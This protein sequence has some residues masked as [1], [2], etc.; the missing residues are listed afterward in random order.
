[1]LAST[2]PLPAG[3]GW[4]YEF[5]WDGVRALATIGG[6]T[7]R[8]HARSGA[9]ITAAY[10]EL[11]PLA[12]MLA[13][14]VL[15]GEVVAL[16][17]Q[18]RPS[19]TA[20]AERMHV[21]EPGRAARLAAAI[22]V[23]YMIFDLLG[24]DGADLTQVPYAQ[25]RALLDGL[26]LVGEHWLVPPSFVDG[27]AT[28]ATAREYALEGVVAKRLTSLYRPGVRSPDWV[29]VKAELSAEFVV[30]G[31]RPGVRTL[32]AL[33][34]GVPR[35]DGRLA[36]RGRVGG[37]ISGA[38]ERALLAALRPLTTVESPFA[39]P[40]PREDA[41]DATWV[42]PEVVVEIKYGQR[43]PDGRLRFPRFLRLRP[44]VSPEE[45]TDA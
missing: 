14:A 2:G 21:R 1:M 22:P 5:K 18:G 38:A 9:E 35:P 20:L 24:L 36:F 31:F 15:D 17:Q 11:A 42:R 8:L 10:P 29:K 12:A 13:D 32:G 16:D 41:K 23:T 34:I 26:D 37:G 7:L 45:C 30:G 19:F 44:D 40:L 27:P 6:G 39:D 3:P 28:L 25:R 43:T 4:A 33:L